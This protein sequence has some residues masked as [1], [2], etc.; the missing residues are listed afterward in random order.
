MEFEGQAKALEGEPSIGISFRCA[1]HGQRE[2]VLQS[3]IGRD[4]SGED[5]D[6][7]LDKLRDAC[8]RQYAW[9][10]VEDLELKIKQEHINAMQHQVRMERADEDIKRQWDQ[11]NRRGDPRLTA[12]QL[13]KQKEA[14]D[15]TEA[16][17]KRLESL[18]EDLAKWKGRYANGRVGSLRD[19]AG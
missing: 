13:Q 6:K 19:G 2:M 9:G 8:E 10:Q 17:K 14:Y 16:I 18:H 15:V 3:F 5:L 12:A 1:L 7:L 11:G 4:C